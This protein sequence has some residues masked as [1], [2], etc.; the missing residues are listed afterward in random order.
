M[1]GRHRQSGLTLV[2]VLVSVVLLAILLVPAM[3][4][5]QTGIVGAEVHGDLASGHL[6]LQVML[7][8]APALSLYDGDNLDADNDP[9]TG[10][11]ADLLWIRLDIED[12]VHTLETIRARGY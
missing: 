6:Y 12:S 3:R 1:T 9:F 7:N 10:T 8:N 5:L 4:A 11:E 2:E